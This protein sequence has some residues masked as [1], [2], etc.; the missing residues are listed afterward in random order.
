[1]GTLREANPS[2][3]VNTTTHQRRHPPYAGDDGPETDVEVDVAVV[4]GGI[5]G[6]STA[7]ELTERGARVAVLEA[8][9]LCSGATGYTT[10]KI[11]SLHGLVYADLV[12]HRGEAV[13]R[14]Y[15]DANQAGL[16]KIVEW[17][18]RYEI[19][20]DLSRRAALTYT[21][22]LATADRVAR[23]VTAARRLGLP[24]SA[25]TTT[26]LPYEV[27]AAIRVDDQAQFHPRA[28]CLALAD[29]IVARGGRVHEGTRVVDVRSGSP[30]VIRTT[31]AELRAGAVVLATHLPI[32]DRGGF[33]AKTAPSRSYALAVRLRSSASMPA[34]MYLSVD[35]PSRSLRSALGDEVLVVGGEGHPVGEDT[36]TA[37]R[38]DA[39]EEWA[40]RHFTVDVVAARWSAQ[41]YVPV[42]GTPFVGRQLPHSPV[43]VA[44]GFQKWG[45]ANATAAATIIADL[46]DGRDNEWS[47]AY[48]AT[49]A[50]SPLT[51]KELYVRNVSTVARHLVGARLRPRAH[52][53]TDPPTCR[54]LGCRL[55]FNDADASWD[56]P[57]HGSR[58]AADDGRVI[59]GPATQDLRR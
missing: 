37:E 44:T 18:G 56:C 25:T 12:E 36:G 28:Y 5:A 55:T 13:A 45:M 29:V 47:V 11:T 10:A 15:A 42:D 4:G 21:T 22:E 40:R 49:R 41:D 39:L 53:G 59:E 52:D 51:S 8:G 6:L 26:E 3:W 20:C 54:H 43:L 17:V 7:L 23:E 31:T 57:C 30:C 19:D 1:M 9:N 24:A 16:A 35:S 38:Y 46:L 27:A 14:A 58:Y 33:F 32:L 2:I 48:D 50:W 34:G